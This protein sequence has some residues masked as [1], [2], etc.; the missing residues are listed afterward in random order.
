MRDTTITKFSVK[1]CQAKHLEINSKITYPIAN[2]NLA[3]AKSF[4]FYMIDSFH[5]DDNSLAIMLVI[6]ALF[7][8][9]AVIVGIVICLIF[10]KFII[11]LF[12]AGILSTSVLLGFQQKSIIVPVFGGDY[13]VLSWMLF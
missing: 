6:G 9:V 8:A 11:S 3:E 4:N 2:Y 7:F 1:Y 5:N 10:T 12:A 13:N